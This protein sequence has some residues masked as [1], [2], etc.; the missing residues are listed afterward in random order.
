[1]QSWRV[2]HG[3]GARQQE[4]AGGTSGSSSAAAAALPWLRVP[5]RFEP[6]RCTP[7][8]QVPGM[9]P[10]LAARLGGAGRWVGSTNLVGGPV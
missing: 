9:D 7:L 6:G 3:G 8:P 4:A 10:R 1:V 2:M 5:L